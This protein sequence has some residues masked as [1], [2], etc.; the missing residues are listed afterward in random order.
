MSGRGLRRVLAV[1][2]FAYLSLNF[3]YFLRMHAQR[4]RVH[5]TWDRLIATLLQRKDVFDRFETTVSPR[6][7]SGRWDE[8]K[9]TNEFDWQGS[10]PFQPGH[11]T[12]MKDADL[13][14][15]LPVLELER[16]RDEDHAIRKFLEA[17]DATT[18][19]HSEFW[20][21]YERSALEYNEA[22]TIFGEHFLWSITLNPLL[23]E[24]ASY[25]SEPCRTL[26]ALPVTSSNAE[27]KSPVSGTR[28]R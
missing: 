18:R 28:L 25:L 2:A 14:M 4:K 27:L 13:K 19:H 8:I 11:I 12:R 22:R 10:D 15:Y 26:P 21:A 6:I 23:F 9:R 16:R 5:A 7:G 20:G 1:V 24:E 17:Y 3:Y